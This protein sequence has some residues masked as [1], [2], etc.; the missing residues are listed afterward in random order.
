MRYRMDQNQELSIELEL[1][2]EPEIDFS[3]EVENPLTHVV[4]PNAKR[5]QILELEEK[6]RV[7][8]MSMNKKI[9]TVMKIVK[10]EKELGKHEKAL[11]LLSALNQHN[12]NAT[13][14]NQ[15][16]IL[17]AGM[18][19]HERAQNY[20]REAA[21][22]NPSWSIPLFNLS[23]NYERER[24]FDEAESSIDEAI[25]REP[26]PVYYVQK[27]EIFSKQGRN[28]EAQALRNEALDQFGPVMTLSDRE[29]YWFERAALY[30]VDLKRQQEVKAEKNRRSSTDLDDEAEIEGV[31]PDY[32][33]A[34]P[35]RRS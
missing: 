14:L 15:M 24:K 9:E 10:L 20:Y 26:N 4:N 3:F 16:G 19:D 6:M 1:A 13:L 12:Q 18:R 31:L 2:D 34:R 33:D 25:D 35:A 8:T 21:R 23:V 7:E 5:E 11:S 28:V 30:A 17:C 32:I 22:L 29:L 27:A